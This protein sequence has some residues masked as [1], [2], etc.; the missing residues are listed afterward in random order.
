MLLLSVV[1]H[2]SAVT[3]RNKRALFMKNNPN[4][5]ACRPGKVIYDYHD[6]LMVEKHDIYTNIVLVLK[7]WSACATTNH[8]IGVY[9]F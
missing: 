2:Y 1:Q 8:N 3:Y 7:S 9:V 6:Q 4:G 5:L